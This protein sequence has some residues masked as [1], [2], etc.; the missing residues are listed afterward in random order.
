MCCEQF[1][2]AHCVLI[3][4]NF[5]LWITFFHDERSETVWLMINHENSHHI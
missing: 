3:I 5:M 2:I 1:L 4:L